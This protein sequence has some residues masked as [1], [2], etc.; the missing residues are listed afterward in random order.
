MKSGGLLSTR[1]HFVKRISFDYWCLRLR[2]NPRFL[3]ELRSLGNWMCW[4]AMSLIRCPSFLMLV[5]LWVWGY[6]SDSSDQALQNQVCRRLVSR[7]SLSP[8][9][10]EKNGGESQPQEEGQDPGRPSTLLRYYTCPLDQVITAS[11]VGTGPGATSLLS[12][13]ATPV[14]WTR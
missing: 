6:E 10:M 9:R 4:P 5:S 1:K 11:G 14:L 7:K 2:L 12:V 13:I 3:V 8:E